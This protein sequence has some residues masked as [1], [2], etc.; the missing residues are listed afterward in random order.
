VYAS[1]ISLNSSTVADTL[2]KD[3]LFFAFPIAFVEV[4]GWT[5][6]LTGVTFVSIIV[7]EM[8]L[9]GIEK[10]NLPTLYV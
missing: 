10:P 7:R 4:R 6:S 9:H 1:A 5:E 3:L 8:S 2:F